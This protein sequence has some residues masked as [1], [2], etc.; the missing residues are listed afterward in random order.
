MKNTST[1][2]AAMLFAVAS[3]AYADTTSNSQA[4]AQPTTGQG[5]ATTVSTS[6]AAAQ[7]GGHATKGLTTAEQNITAPHGKTNSKAHSHTRRGSRHTGS[8]E[9]V[10]H[11]AHVERPSLPE[12]PGR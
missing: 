12:R 9:R 1:L 6:P 3:A 8:M 5:A 7:S 2:L 10:E 11:P 4:P